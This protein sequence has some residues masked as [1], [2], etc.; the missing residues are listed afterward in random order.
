MIKVLLSSHAHMAS[1]MKSSL[2]LF[3]S[4][5]PALEVFDAYTDEDQRSVKDVVD[6][7]LEK[8]AECELKLLVSDMFGGSVCNTMT[9]YSERSDVLVITGVNLS[10]MLDL[11]LSVDQGLS[12]E[13]IVQK[14]NNAREAMKVVEITE[15]AAEPADDFF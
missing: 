13:E 14:L 7:F 1:G 4:D 15:F 8:N 3:L 9:P 10:F 6:T 5:M 2:A 12:K 11:M